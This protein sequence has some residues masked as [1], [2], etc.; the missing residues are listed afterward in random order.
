MLTDKRYQ[1]WT[2]ELF[3]QIPLDIGKSCENE[4]MQFFTESD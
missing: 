2:L 1:F 4:K 3:K